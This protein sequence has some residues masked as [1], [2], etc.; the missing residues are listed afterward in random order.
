[1]STTRLPL[2][3]GQPRGAGL[4]SLAV[5]EPDSAGDD[6]SAG[7][8]ERVWDRLFGGLTDTRAAFVGFSVILMSLVFATAGAQQVPAAAALLGL[9]ACGWLVAGVT[10]AWFGATRGDDAPA[11]VRYTLTGLAGLGRVVAVTVIIG[12]IV[13]VIF[14]VA[15]LLTTA[16][17]SDRR[18]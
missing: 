15:V 8:L 12:T 5:L 3:Y 9:A 17:M 4:A 7:F 11:W 6:G 13:A 2:W 10:C 18:Y 16:A 14:A 1:M